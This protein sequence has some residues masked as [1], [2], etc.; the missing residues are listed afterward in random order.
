M[1][2]RRITL[3]AGALTI[4]YILLIKIDRCRNPIKDFKNASNS[5]NAGKLRFSCRNR[6]FCRKSWFI[7]IVRNAFVISGHDSSMRV[8]R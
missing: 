8:S 5:S 2:P 6:N 1:C 7:C 3:I 4:P